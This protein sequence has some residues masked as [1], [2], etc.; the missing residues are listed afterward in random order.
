MQFR[1]V[2]IKVHFRLIPKRKIRFSIIF[3]TGISLRISLKVMVILAAL[4]AR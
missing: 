1:L 2:E 4:F 3:K